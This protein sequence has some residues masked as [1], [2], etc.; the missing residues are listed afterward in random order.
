MSTN[1][2]ESYRPDDVTTWRIRVQ[3][4]IS[5]AACAHSHAHAQAR[6]HARTHNTNMYYLLL[7]HGN[8]DSRTLL[9]I[10]LYVHCLACLYMSWYHWRIVTV[11]YALYSQYKLSY[12]LMW[13]SYVSLFSPSGYIISETLKGLGKSDIKRTRS[14][15]HEDGKCQDLTTVHFTFKF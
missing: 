11:L 4:W 6:A 3:C 5:K 7:F 12:S 13:E 14:N 15:L 2:V 1:L 10:T 8:N 9:N